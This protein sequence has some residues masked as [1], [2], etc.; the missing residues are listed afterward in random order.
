[1]AIVRVALA[2]ETMGTVQAGQRR[3]AVTVNSAQH[4]HRT[5][6]ALTGREEE[7]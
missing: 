6:S 1:M 2:L 3:V 7:R 5:V 4:P